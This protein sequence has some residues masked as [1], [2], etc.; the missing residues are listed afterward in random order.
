MCTYGQ[1][2]AARTDGEAS[3]NAFAMQ[4][5]SPRFPCIHSMHG[6]GCS[7]SVNEL[8]TTGTPSPGA[9]ALYMHVYGYAW[10]TAIVCIQAAI[11]HCMVCN[12]I[13]DRMCATQC[14]SR[15]SS[16]TA[17]RLRLVVRLT[18]LHKPVIPA[19]IRVLPASSTTLATFLRVVEHRQLLWGNGRIYTIC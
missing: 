14:E 2:D 3:V 16:E 1:A 19:G 18:R 15:R 11:P 13:D 7:L 6:V 8:L 9:T 17:V 12:D 4:P 10:Q 5:G